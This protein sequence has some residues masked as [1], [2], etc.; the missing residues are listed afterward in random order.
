[1][2]VA[3]MTFALCGLGI[4]P[5]GAL[6]Q[7]EA[8]A[9]SDLDEFDPADFP[10][11]AYVIDNPFMPLI[12]GTRF[13]WTG[14]A[15]EDGEPIRRRIVTSVTDLTKQI[16]GVNALVVLEQ[17]Y[18]DGELIESELAFRAQDLDGSV[19]HL[20]EYTELWEGE[21]FVGG[22][23]WMQGH[24]DGAR[25]G[26]IMQADP[27]LD[28][29]SYAQGF[30]P[31]PYFWTDCGRIIEM[32][33]TVSEVAGDFEDVLVVEEF[34]AS[35]PDAKQ[36]KFY[37]PDVGLVRV[38]YAGTDEER[39]QLGLLAREQLDAE[40]VATLREEALAH[41]ARAYVYASTAP[42]VHIELSQ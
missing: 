11:D 22:Q 42:A 13:I 18:N 39:E 32:G 15:F 6:G 37:A 8:A 24:L 14:S 20:G 25:A 16:G 35:D 7:D 41:E 27:Q 23:A 33:A 10:S 36:L 12:P 3:A 31:E 4:T 34:D 2:A 26:I 29:P 40:E 21:E 1:M 38:G 30:A 9:E 19:W 5:A 28:R 17:D